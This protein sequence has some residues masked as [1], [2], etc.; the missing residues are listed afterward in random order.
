[1]ESMWRLCG[2]KK[3]RT[4]SVLAFFYILIIVFYSG[5]PPTKLSPG[6]ASILNLLTPFIG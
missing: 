3:A 1:M 2:K 4:N 5:M 6:S